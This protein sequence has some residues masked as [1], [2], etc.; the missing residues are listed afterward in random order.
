ML[1][2]EQIDFIYEDLGR[3]FHIHGLSTEQLDPDSF[4]EGK[5]DFLF[6][7]GKLLDEGLL[8]LGNRKSE[9]IIEG[10]TTELVERFRKCFPALYE[11]VNLAGVG[12]LWLVTQ[13]CPFIA[14][15]LLQ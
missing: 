8:K 1:T 12:G 4:E 5:N 11:E 10:T 13:E 7:I 3:P 6:L 14:H 15:S 2:Q 9:L